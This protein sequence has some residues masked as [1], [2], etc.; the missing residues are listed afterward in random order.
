M[1]THKPT[2]HRIPPQLCSLAPSTEPPGHLQLQPYRVSM[3]RTPQADFHQCARHANRV[4]SLVSRMLTLISRILDTI[5][6]PE[7]QRENALL[8]ILIGLL[9]DFQ[10]YFQLQ[11]PSTPP[12]A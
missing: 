12:S 2:R 4:L 7:E 8:R 9:G 5:Q 1:L 10:Q 6:L 3:P 11:S